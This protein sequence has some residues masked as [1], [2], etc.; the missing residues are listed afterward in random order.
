MDISSMHGINEVDYL[1]DDFIIFETI[2]KTDFKHFVDFPTRPNAMI[3]SLCLEGKCHMKIN[4]KDNIIEKNT[5]TVIAQDRILQN[6]GMSIDYHSYVIGMSRTFYEN[7]FS[8][9]KDIVPLFLYFNDHPIYSMSQD[10]I[11]CLY[12]YYKMIHKKVKEA[13][14]SYRRDII[15]GLLT[16]FLFDFYNIYKKS[17]PIVTKPKTRKEEIF[18]HF[19]QAVSE[20]YQSERTVAVYAE[21]LYLTPKHLSGVVKEVSGKTP[22]EWIDERVILEAKALLKSSEMN[23]QQIAETLHFTNQSFFGKYFRHHVGM[24]PK[25]YRRS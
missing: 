5:V 2:G 19:L 1:D 23:I 18:S 16:A 15:Q 4:L 6:V 25:E 7:I 21:K 11:D 17:T 10:E 9:Q 20:N 13:N 8:R 3:I 24:S 22:G 14:N 12:G